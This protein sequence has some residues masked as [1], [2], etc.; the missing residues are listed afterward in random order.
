MVAPAT[1]ESPETTRPVIFCWATQNKEKKE[2]KVSSS[3]CEIPECGLTCFPRKK[4][5]F[6]NGRFWFIVFFFNMKVSPVRRAWQSGGNNQNDRSLHY[7][8]HGS[9]RFKLSIFCREIRNVSRTFN[10]KNSHV[11]IQGL[12]NFVGNLSN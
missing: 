11:A 10:N 1:A 7:L 5:F 2:K 9:I 4:M 12:G 8:R 3:M 6:P